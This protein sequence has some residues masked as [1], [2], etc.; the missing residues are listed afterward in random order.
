MVEIKR[1]DDDISVAEM[2]K[3]LNESYQDMDEQLSKLA[4][5]CHFQSMSFERDDVEYSKTWWECPVC[6]HQRPT[7]GQF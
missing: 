7:Y 3:G 2:F 6:G 4:P 1:V 5:R